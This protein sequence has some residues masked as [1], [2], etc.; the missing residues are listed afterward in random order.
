MHPTEMLR[1]M[2]FEARLHCG[3][4]VTATCQLGEDEVISFPARVEAVFADAVIVR[5]EADLRLP[6]KVPEEI[7]I[8]RFSGPEWS[9]FNRVEPAVD[10]LL[11]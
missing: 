9:P 3:Q 4:R 2:N 10:S 5:A 7:V 8:P 1:Q 11:S 6:E